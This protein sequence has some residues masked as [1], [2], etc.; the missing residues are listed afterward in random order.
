MT[1]ALGMR[2]YG[3]GHLPGI[4]G[5]EA[6]YGNA[7]SSLIATGNFAPITPNG[8]VAGPGQFYAV[9]VLRLLFPP[10]I[11]LLRVP[12]V[13]ASLGAI[14]LAFQ[15]GRRIGGRSAGLA[16]ALLIAS[17][18]INIAYARFGWDPGYSGLIVLLACYLGLRHKLLLSALTICFGLFVHVT[19]VFA[20]PFLFAV[21]AWDNIGRNGWRGSVQPSLRY[22]L[23][24]AA[25]PLIAFALASRSMTAQ[26]RPLVTTLSDIGQWGDFLAA[27]P[28]MM[29][30]NT[31]FIFLTG[32]GMGPTATFAAAALIILMVVMLALAVIRWRRGSWPNWIGAVGGCLGM[33][34]ALNLLIGIQ[35]LTPHMERYGFVI[36]APIAVTFAVVTVAAIG[37]RI[38]VVLTSAVAALLLLAAAHY[39]FRPLARGAAHAHTAFQTGIPEPKAAAAHAVRAALSTAPGLAVIAEDYW[40]AEPVQYLAGLP[41]VVRGDYPGRPQAIGPGQL[42]LV[43]EGGEAE[44][45]LGAYG[46]AMPVWQG[47][48][49][50]GGMR[51]RLWIVPTSSGNR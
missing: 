43:Y 16:A 33:L 6:W 28:G 18:P 17:V 48:Q 4:N 32:D 51:L 1:V 23:M 29:T 8:N 38:G 10:S 5:D 2:I 14:A 27:V 9:S 39:Y 49:V 31:V 40:L 12:T 44:G 26:P 20:V 34:V 45:R 24:L 35:A 47:K 21:V 11:E 50:A 37:P 36:V 30:G 15:I 22:G 7:A 25:V 3:L 42:W 46:P 41:T 19:N 13:L